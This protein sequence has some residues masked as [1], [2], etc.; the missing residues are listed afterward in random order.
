MPPARGAP[1]PVDDLALRR[2][3]K[4]AH[5]ILRDPVQRSGLDG[6]ELLAAVVWP[7][8]DELR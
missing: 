2:R 6:V 3:M 1:S 8:A 7:Q 4:A 5:E